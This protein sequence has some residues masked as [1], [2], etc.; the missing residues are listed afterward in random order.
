MY[1][2]SIQSHEERRKSS[3]L[4]LLQHLHTLGSRQCKVSGELVTPPPLPISSRKSFGSLTPTLVAMIPRTTYLF[5]P[6]FVIRA[7]TI[8]HQSFLQTVVP[9]RVL[10]GVFDFTARPSL[11]ADVFIPFTPL[12]WSQGFRMSWFPGL[13]L[14]RPTYLSLMR[15]SAI[16]LQKPKRILRGEP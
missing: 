5:H 16:T 4:S 3:P 14:G 11:L 12:Q 9:R 7:L 10:W 6:V 13:A 2:Y 1:K 8:Y 15:H